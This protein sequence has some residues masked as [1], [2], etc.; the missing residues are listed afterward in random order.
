MRQGQWEPYASNAWKTA[1]LIKNNYTE[2]EELVRIMP[3][4]NLMFEYN[5]K[6][7]LENRI[8]WVDENF[9]Q[10]F[11]FP[12][13]KGNPHEA[14]KASNKVVISESTAHKYF[15]TEDPMGKVFKLNDYATELQVSGVM[16]DMPSNSH[17]HFDFLASSA[18][19][20]NLY[21]EG[22]FTNVG[23]DSQFVYARFAPG[24]DPA[25][26]EATFPDFINNNLDF[27]KST[28]FK[29]FLQ[30]LESIH[31][32]SNIGRDGPGVAGRDPPRWT[33]PTCRWCPSR[34]T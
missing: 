33:C 1:E 31:L 14:V 10:L 7:I 22:L 24:T 2:V 21:S 13:I 29:M 34:A 11:N 23:W 18:T 3:D 9:F 16:K 6:K 25:R 19:L 12:L 30:P 26:I 28:T 8:A 4:N 27:W 17:F 5:D 32:E 15:G 20:R